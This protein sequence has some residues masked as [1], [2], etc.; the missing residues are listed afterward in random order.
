[1]LGS[2]C[3]SGGRP[4][5]FVQNVETSDATHPPRG[6]EKT[7]VMSLIEVQGSAGQKWLDRERGKGHTGFGVVVGVGPG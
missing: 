1:M 7:L 4:Q 2:P 5:T 6:Y 3:L